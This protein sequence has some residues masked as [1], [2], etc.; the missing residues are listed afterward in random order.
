MRRPFFLAV[1]AGALVATPAL[2][3]VTVRY[4]AVLPEGAQASA[5]ASI[6]TLTISADDSGQARLEVLA[7]G[8][9]P[10]GGRQPGVAL[11]TREGVGYF[12][13]SGPMPQMQVVARQEDALALVM[14]FGGPLLRQNAGE[15]AAAEALRQ[16]VEITPVGPE[17]VAGVRGNLYRVVLVAG[18]TRTPPLEIV[19]ATDPRMAPVGREFVRLTESLRP[20]VVELVGG[21]PQI[22]AA[23]RGLMGLGAPLRI[24]NEVRLDSIDTADLP[25]DLFALPGPVMDRAQLAQMAQMLMSMGQG[26]RGM[27]SIPGMP[28]APPQGTPPTPAPQ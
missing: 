19:V 8:A 22:Y 12:A 17:T 10:P 3:D 20:L 2:A 4:K 5:R 1:L 28:P 7:P 14:Q 9:P 13:L 16:R 26:G 11:I 15:G 24:G 27:P 18:E 23:V 6:P 21:E 25:D